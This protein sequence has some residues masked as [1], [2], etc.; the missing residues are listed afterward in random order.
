M[1]KHFKTFLKINFL[2][3]LI[4]TQSSCRKEK[5]SW[6]TQL[7]APIAQTELKLENLISADE[8]QTNA[9]GSLKLVF[10]NELANILLT[11][12]FELPNETI[13]F[14]SSLQTLKLDD[15]SSSVRISLGDIALNE[16][17]FIGAYI[18]ASNGDSA[19]VPAINGLS[20]P[21]I[22]IDNSSVFETIDIK[23]GMMEIVI[24]NGLPVDVKDVNIEV[25]NKVANP[26][27]PLG[28]ET[29]LLIPAGGTETLTM[30]LSGKIVSSEL[31]ATI[32]NI[33]TKASNGKVL[34]DTSN[35]IIATMTLK[36]IVPNSATAI[37]PDQNLI[38]S[39]SLAFLAQN[40]GAMIKKMIVS[41]GAIDIDVFSSLQDSMFITYS[42]PNLTK[43]GISFKAEVG[44]APAPAGGFASKSV[45][46]NFDG[47]DFEL[48]GYGIES[49]YG[50]DLNGNAPT[51][52]PDTVNTYV[53]ILTARM[54]Y[55][56][57]MVPISLSDTVFMKA[58]IGN[59]TPAYIEGYMGKDTIEIG[60][61]TIDLGIFNNHLSGKLKVEDAKISVVVEN[62]VGAEA[63]LQIGAI[64]GTN[65]A[66]NSTV[67]LSGTGVTSAHNLAAATK[68]G[69]DPPINTTTTF[70]QLTNSNS[71]AADF[72]G[73]LPN[74]LNY[75]LTARLN[76][77]LPVPS[78]TDV[79]NSPPNFLYDGYGVNAKLNVEVPLSMIA[80][81]L[82]LVDTIDFTYNG[83]TKNFIKTQFT[84]VVENG[85]GF[86]ATVNLVLMD[87]TGNEL[88]TLISNGFIA[89]GT[90]DPATG[91][92]ISSN[93][94]LIRF[95]V[96][97]NKM[98]IIKTSSKIKAVINLH[99][100]NMSDDSKVFHKIFSSDSFKLKLIGSAVYNVKF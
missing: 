62:G 93:K 50:Q 65:P 11:D 38:D 18:I 4:L 95:Q 35:A 24:Q 22:E 53:Q 1:A 43:E 27:D 59:V 34:I 58:V 86:D 21:P 36:D 45:T 16:G 41:K 44:L 3:L 7:K 42:I 20:S 61:N 15:D 2:G 88:D 79:I 99:S 89:R 12:V 26:T 91:K 64:N 57:L 71:N 28:N 66:N 87:D 82:S 17:G 46:I 56:G 78:Y 55:T 9:D 40:N 29:I 85:F 19:T 67:I 8:I 97:A 47:Y 10:E 39:T 23:S 30:D 63:K 81:N 84:L 74:N 83:D 76:G 75:S 80:D 32:L 94:S 100:H 60:P 37:W 33:S 5:T 52:D 69:S 98:A 25:K 92:I 54:K 49:S 48:N 77:D 68:T 90:V 6:E 51:I 31:I 70:V 72:L 14:G 13:G 73:N 96:D